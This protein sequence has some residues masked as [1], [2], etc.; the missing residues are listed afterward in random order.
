MWTPTI[1]LL[2]S[3]GIF[4]QLLTGLNL[5]FDPQSGTSAWSGGGTGYFSVGVLIKLAMML[6]FLGLAAKGVMSNRHEWHHILF[7]MFAY[8]A[9]FIPTTT[10]IIDNLYNGNSIP[11]NHIPIGIAYPAG[12]MSEIGFYMSNELQQADSSVTSDVPA[13]SLAQGG[14]DAPLKDYLMLRS[15]PFNFVKTNENMAHTIITFAGDCAADSTGFSME[16]DVN[17]STNVLSSILNHYNSA[18]RTVEYT[19]QAPWGNDQGG[20]P[21][22]CAQAD[23]DITTM[24]AAFEGGNST[25]G[26]TA[27]EVDNNQQQVNVH[28]LSSL[29]A[30][31]LNYA[32]N[33][34]P[35]AG[36]SISEYVVGNLNSAMPSCST[37]NSGGVVCT[38]AN[39]GAQFINNEIM[40][41]MATDGYDISTAP[42]SQMSQSALPYF[43]EM[44]DAI[45]NQEA[46]HAASATSFEANVIPLMTILQF[47][48]F[49][50]T[51]LVA[52]MFAFNAV[53]GSYGLFGKYLQFGVWT[54]TF[55]PAVTIINDYSQYQ[56]QH[57]IERMA[58]GVGSTAAPYTFS[59]MTNGFGHVQLAL[60]NANMM[61]TLAPMLTLA[62]ITGSYYSLTQLAKSFSS[63]GTGAMADTMAPKIAPPALNESPPVYGMTS[64]GNGAVMNS[65]VEMGSAPSMN[66]GASLGNAASAARTE[67]AQQAAT[68]ST[69]FQTA[70]QSQL[71]AAQE[72]GTTNSVVNSASGALSN[73][74]SVMKSETG[75]IAKSLGLT[76]AQVADAVQG[77]ALSGGPGAVGAALKAEMKV[78]KGHKLT[79][80]QQGAI[81]QAQ[82]LSSNMGESFKKLNSV[83]GSSGISSGT[84][85]ALN[86]SFA[87][88]KNASDTM[89]ETATK[90]QTYS[91]AENEAESGGMATSIGGLQAW[92]LMNAQQGT[93]LMT[94]LGSLEKQFRQLDSGATEKGMQLGALSKGSPAMNQAAGLLYAADSAGLS[95]NY[96]AQAQMES[97]LMKAMGKPTANLGASAQ[98]ITAGKASVGGAVA[99]TTNS[100]EG[101]TGGGVGV[102]ATPLGTNP[103][104]SSGQMPAVAAE[105]NSSFNG[106][107]AA[108]PGIAALHGKYN[109][110]AEVKKDNAGIAADGK[111]ASAAP[112]VPRAPSPPGD[113]GSPA[114]GAVHDAMEYPLV[115]IGGGALVNFGMDM[116]GAAAGGSAAKWAA[117]GLMNKFGN[118]TT[119]SGQWEKLG[120]QYPESTAGGDGAAAAGGGSPAVSTNGAGSPIPEAASDL[121]DSLAPSEQILT[122]AAESPIVVQAVEDAVEVGADLIP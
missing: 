16:S 108:Q 97:L 94:K 22:S 4:Q 65:N 115:T 68:A 34:G 56:V 5:I 90:A 113:K 100:V 42:N 3:T 105:A 102:G 32:G 9:L 50:L 106:Q 35:V 67:T 29:E 8:V 89:A 13:I 30:S 109:K 7:G 92:Q 101:H 87:E 86:K 64:T 47:L 18:G 85:D 121:G 40:G 31:L 24:W 37:G 20:T 12:L 52:V 61:V 112:V 93:H 14:F 122:N 60:S 23:A 117:K 54:Q 71:S 11:I 98:A 49:A 15:A 39:N 69:A 75:K 78:S 1:Y 66:L 63:E 28:T 76:D 58:A 77:A 44:E 95:G 62:V 111:G 110:S 43:C 45:G 96:G 2:G 119:E 59:D 74:M 84:K 104:L 6:G 116:V 10:V 27:V 88:A 81:E 19:N 33:P 38:A 99:A 70:A 46:H 51:P 103:G 48:F 41:C 26:W 107:A 83:V 73:D 120:K 21:V 79:A 25:S 91:N 114:W 55:L 118:K 82:S 53:Q 72:S 36:G 57:A 80:A 17:N